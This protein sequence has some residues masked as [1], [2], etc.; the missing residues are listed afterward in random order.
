MPIGGLQFVAYELTAGSRAGL[1][2]PATFRDFDESIEELRQVIRGIQ[3]LGYF[4]L[5]SLGR[6]HRGE[7]RCYDCHSNN[8]KRYA[9]QDRPWGD[10]FIAAECEEC[11]ETWE[12]DVP[13]PT[14]YPTAHLFCYSL[15]EPTGDP[16]N[17]GSFTNAELI[18]DQWC[19]YED[20]RSLTDPKY[21]RGSYPTKTVLVRR[22]GTALIEGKLEGVED[23]FITWKYYVPYDEGMRPSLGSGHY[24]MHPIEEAYVDYLIRLMALPL[25]WDYELVY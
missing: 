1:R 3:V 10:V 8:I 6:R 24:D 14:T 2:A 19:K 20:P 16:V 5:I 12:E 7:R 18:A 11:G 22:P 15:L 9:P 25:E 13:L 4:G 23:L 17:L 21:R